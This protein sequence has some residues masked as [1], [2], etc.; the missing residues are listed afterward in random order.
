MPALLDRVVLHEATTVTLHVAGALPGEQFT[1]TFDRSELMSVAGM[2][3]MARPHFLAIVSSATLAASLARNG[4][5]VDGFV[6]ENYT[7][8]GHNAPP[9]GRLVLSDTGEPK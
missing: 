9:R 4:S 6:V 3:P 5:Q 2:P 1:T 7:A 8:G